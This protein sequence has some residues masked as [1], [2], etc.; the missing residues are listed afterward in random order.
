MALRKLE[1]DNG[2]VMLDDASV[3]R[4][5]TIAPDGVS[6]DVTASTR[7]GLV[8]LR[9]RWTVK[10][11]P[12]RMLPLEILNLR[13][14]EFI[15][16]G[17]F[18]GGRKYELLGETPDGS[19]KLGFP[20]NTYYK[21]R[22]N[23]RRPYDTAIFSKMPIACWQAK[24]KAFA[25]VFPKQLMLPHGP[26]PIFIEAGGAGAGVDFSAALMPEFEVERKPIGWF[27][28]GS[29]TTKQHVALEK[30]QSFEAG[31]LL[32]AADTWVECVRLCEKHLYASVPGAEPL[33]AETLAEKLEASLRYYDRVWD[34]RNR[35]HAHLPVKN[36]TRFESTEFK[37]SHVTDDL[38]KL[39]LYRRL[40][41]LGFAELEDRK[42]GLAAR[43]ASGAYC[44]REDGARLWHT[45]TYF[46][47]SDLKAF[48]HHGTGFVGFPGGM[49]T[50][51]RRLFE[52]CSIDRDESLEEM[53]RSAADWLLRQQSE[54]GSWPAL[55]EDTPGEAHDGCVAS[56]A[57]SVR[58]LLLG[59]R[60]T[61]DARYK[62][63]AEAGIRYISRDESFFQCGRYL[64]DVDSDNSDGLTTEACIHALLDWHS[65]TGDAAALAAAEKW[66][67]HALQ[68]I[69]PRLSEYVAEPSFDGLSHSI[70]PRIDVWGGLLA[71]RA[72]LR[73]SKASGERLWSDHAWRLFRGIAKLQER[74]GGFSET[75]FLDFPSGLES[76]HIEPTFVTDAFVEFI[77]DLCDDEDG[78]LANLIAARHES[79]ARRHPPLRPTG[80]PVGLVSFSEERPECLIDERLRLSP[81][82][83]GA[84]DLRGKTSRAA[85]TMMREVAPGRA[86][87]KLVPAA[88]IM[89]NRH[90]V[91]PPRTEIGKSAGIEVLSSVAEDSADGFAA[92]RFHTALHDIAF[93]VVSEGVD[94]EGFPAA[95]VEISINTLAGD[96]RVEQVRID[97]GGHYQVLSVY[98]K[99]AMLVSCDGSEYSIEV[100]EGSV[101]AIIRDGDRA[102]FDI[103]MCSNWNFFGEYRLRL[104]VARRPGNSKEAGS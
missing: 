22:I 75:W 21:F 18:V 104:R 30:G 76:I 102:A 39:V 55:A 93:S 86:L 78:P 67:F 90:R 27:G 37:H 6:A 1:I 15:S 51:A 83:D 63:A 58:A 71:A 17:A 103:S 84:Y 44:Y 73:L 59:Y 77:L 19:R 23:A 56:T 100:I 52:Y 66:A 24:D 47:G 3:G 14:G 20:Y 32:I 85:Y 12:D 25:V 13:L 97:L 5:A 81:A 33:S 42:R 87:L 82:F 40:M 69:R 95:D 96:I 89:L 16:T 94:S 61:E 7:E 4:L 34:S 28:R 53:A 80:E 91:N 43:L 2:Q 50:V 35:T 26:A 48:T 99:E 101:D 88:K 10:T 41:S 57:E 62:A 92:R 45:T 74:D 36:E 79:I 9:I 31:F 11:P 98:G 49:A 38:T 68:W 8:A 72:F 46:D 70:T 60:L 54:Q 64:R 29:K 65:S